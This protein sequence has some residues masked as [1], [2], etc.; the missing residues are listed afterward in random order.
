MTVIRFSSSRQRR[1]AD[2]LVGDVIPFF[3]KPYY[4]LF[5]LKAPL[6]PARGGAAF[7]PW[8]H[9]MSRDLMDWHEMPLALTPG[10]EGAPDANGC[11]TGSVICPEGDGPFH[12]FY[13]GHAPGSAHGPQTICH[14]VSFDLEKW[15]KDPGNPLVAPDRR[16]YERDDWR[17]PFVFWHTDERCYWMLITA[18]E[19]DAPTPRAGC[20][21]LAKSTD[22]EK[23]EVGP[24]LW[25]P[26]IVY[27]PECPD[28]FAIEQ[29]WYMLFSTNETR[30][31]VGHSPA[32]PWGAPA[33]ESLDGPRFYAAKTLSDGKRR[34]LFGWVPTREGETD[35]GAW[36]WGGDLALPRELKQDP[37]G[38]LVIGCPQHISSTF[39]PKR[40]KPDEIGG[41]QPRLGRWMA[42]DD[43]L[44][45]EAP[46]G[47][48]YALCPEAGDDFAAELTITMDAAPTRAGLLLRAG[49]NLQR[50]YV[51]VFEPLL[52]RMS[53][54]PWQSW[55]DAEPWV[56]RPL[57]VVRG[58]PISLQLL[59]ERSILEVV[60][61][62]RC[63]LTCRLYDHRSGVLGVFVE[64][65]I[66]EFSGLTVYALPPG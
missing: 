2:G 30:Y 4:H 65:G 28:V 54:R 23:W 43:V 48:G 59:L 60:A 35:R 21:A 24:P 61:N 52:W 3:W 33:L 58:E 18:R 20:I 17:D 10:D 12:I 38:G 5:Y 66:A 32:G 40:F 7:T 22:L 41:F 56:E 13:T 1:P 57:P 55:G 36:E 63:C 25:S 19:R 46:H 49:E 26:H 39:G 14:A 8:A 16:W 6:P 51:L 11:W 45:G 37:D 29:R 42:S 34:L 50:G 44:V 27:A 47:F 62:Q 9:V 53:L 15:D 31:R 64:N